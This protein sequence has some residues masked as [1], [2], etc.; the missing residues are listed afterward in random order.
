MN[1]NL[2]DFAT[3]EDKFKYLVQNKSLI[4]AQKKSATKRCDAVTYVVPN[5]NKEDYEQKD[6]AT[7]VSDGSSGNILI[8]LVANT[9]NLMDCHDD[10]HIPG[11][12][13]KTLSD[14]KTFLHLQ[15][16]DM[17]FES[18]IS[19][20]MTCYT[21]NM[22]WASL[23]LPY[24]GKTQALIGESIADITRNSYMCDQ[25]RKGW[26]KNHSVGMQYV[27]IV[28]CINSKDEYY[29]EYKANWDKYSSM[30]ANTDLMNEKGHFFAVLQAK[31]IEVS[32]VVRGS[33]W[34][35]P[36][37]S[38]EDYTEADKS[39][40]PIKI[41]PSHDTQ[42]VKSVSYLDLASTIVNIQKS[43]K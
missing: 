9:T 35:T 7:T 15:E 2:P 20:S 27:D 41:E 25:Y 17:E 40:T 14:N 16:H 37:Q 39:V 30:V 32:A 42:S 11:I 36:T 22:T 31:L 1:Y 43:I 18:V 10:V 12:W 33:N 21:K 34:V 13:K 4:I 23:G 24:E 38:V 5:V 26:V 6:A 28:L 3:K 8:K 29:K 19:D